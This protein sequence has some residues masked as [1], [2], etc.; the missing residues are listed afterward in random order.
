MVRVG[1]C[2]SICW[3]P[4]G[5]KHR[6][7]LWQ[8]PQQLCCPSV[9]STNP[10]PGSDT[11]HEMHLGAVNI[12]F[13]SSGISVQMLLHLPLSQMWTQ[14]SL[15]AVMGVGDALGA[16]QVAGLALLPFQVP[17]PWDWE[18]LRGFA[19]RLKQL[20]INTLG[21][22]NKYTSK[23]PQLER[24]SP[25]SLLSCL[26]TDRLSVWGVEEEKQG[27]GVNKENCL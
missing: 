2:P 3:A 6:W 1:E 25:S 21:E 14:L 18:Q 23:R 20:K 16:V 10:P 8:K 24:P 13:P 5:K 11:D 27:C 15:L 17:L 22:K 19:E 7:Y 12:G 4:E 26:S 9:L